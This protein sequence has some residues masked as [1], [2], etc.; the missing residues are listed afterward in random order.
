[1]VVCLAPRWA[2]TPGRGG[3]RTITIT[4]KAMPEGFLSSHLVSGVRPGTIVRLA[5]PQAT[6]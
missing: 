1:M 5:A 3:S 2:P 4:I 6:S